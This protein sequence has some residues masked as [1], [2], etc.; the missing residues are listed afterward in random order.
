M[1]YEV[2]DVEVLNRQEDVWVLTQATFTGAA[3]LRRRKAAYR[4]TWIE[5]A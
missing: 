1:S 2:T 3:I 4:Q 5:L